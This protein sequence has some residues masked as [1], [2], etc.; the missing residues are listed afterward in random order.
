MWITSGITL[1]IDGEQIALSPLAVLCQNDTFR[2]PH[3][4]MGVSINYK[5]FV[6]LKIVSYDL[7]SHGLFPWK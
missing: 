7:R 6:D 3:V 1:C 4:R 2:L 5:L